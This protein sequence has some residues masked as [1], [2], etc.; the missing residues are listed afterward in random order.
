MTKQLFIV[1]VFSVAFLTGQLSIAGNVNSLSEAESA[2]D[3]ESLFDGKNLGAG[4][5]HKGNWKVE[6]GT[7]TR[8]GQGGSL[9]YKANKIPTTSNCDSI[10]RS[11]KAATAVSTIDRGSTSIRFSTTA[12]MSMVR[13]LARVPHRSTSAWPLHTTQQNQSASGTKRESS[14][15]ARS[16]STG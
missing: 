16:F 8:E 14:V 3:F 10:G 7:I 5:E 2:A 13:I 1:V 15:K 4:W 12:F 9:V 11:P 6:D